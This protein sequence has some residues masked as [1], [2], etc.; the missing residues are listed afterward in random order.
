M[1]LKIDV[2]QLSAWTGNSDL[3]KERKYGRERG[4]EFG[5]EIPEGCVDSKI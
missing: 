2:S 5:F 1:E 3:N 4:S